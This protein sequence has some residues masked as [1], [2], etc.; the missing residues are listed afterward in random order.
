MKRYIFV[1]R[2][3]RDMGATRWQLCKA[4]VKLLINRSY[5]KEWYH[6]RSWHN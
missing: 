5:R 3:F 2:C 4:A 6:D 1:L